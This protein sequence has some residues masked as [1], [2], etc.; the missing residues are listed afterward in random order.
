MISQRKKVFFFNNCRFLSLF[1]AKRR[2][3]FVLHSA[4]KQLE[5]A[6]MKLRPANNMI[7]LHSFVVAIM[8]LVTTAGGLKAQGWQF[9]FG[10]S[11]EDEGWAVLQA[12]DEGFIVVGFGESFGTDNDQNIFVVRTDIDGTILWTKYYDEGFQEQ[13]RAIIPTADGNYLIVGNI[14]GKPGESNLVEQA[15]NAQATLY[16]IQTEDSP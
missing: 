7:T 6:L 3:I 4:V 9:N 2:C 14:V 10:G 11:K 15:A 12:E 1:S 8:L 5:L 16:S 13:A